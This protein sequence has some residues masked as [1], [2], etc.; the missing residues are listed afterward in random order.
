MWSIAKTYRYLGK[1][2]EALEIQLDILK[3]DN[4]ID[5]SGY[6][7]EELGELYLLKG[8][9]DKAKDYFG[10]AYAILSKDTWLQ[11][12]EKDRLERLKRLSI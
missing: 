8:D 12:N 10:K 7:F 3:K 2:D 6:T 9:A 4:G 1:H 5:E 11:K